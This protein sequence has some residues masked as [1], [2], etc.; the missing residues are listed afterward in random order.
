MHILIVPLKIW[1][2]VGGNQWR[3]TREPAVGAPQGAAG[4]KAS[5]DQ[6]AHG[7]PRASNPGV[8]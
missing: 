8:S 5:G 2:L 4:A 3:L 6:V 1:A 7:E